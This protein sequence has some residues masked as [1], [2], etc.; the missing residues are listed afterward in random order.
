M[1]PGMPVIVV[2]A[3][4]PLGAGIV[5]ALLHRAGEVRAFVSDPDSAARLK[6]LGVKVA[7]GDVS[8]P[9]H[10]AGASLRAF[11]AV[12]VASAARDGRR[13]AFADDPDVILRSWANAFAE[14]G[15]RRV[16]F[17]D[18]RPSPAV[19]AAF[20]SAAR[21]TAV[22]DLHGLGDAAAASQV[23]RLDDAA[24]LE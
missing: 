23:A 19:V 9:S 22:V 15:V 13:R 7:V 12:A 1:L 18:D 6:D 20:R 2:G 11:S 24:S 4:T 16:I 5:R 10:V 21:E 3:D 17:V 8:D 14:A